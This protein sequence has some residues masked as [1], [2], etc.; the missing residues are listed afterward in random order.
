NEF[1]SEIA[2]SEP[3]LGMSSA[4]SVGVMRQ[5]LAELDKEPI[6]EWADLDDGDFVAVCNY[7][8]GAV[9][10]GGGPT[11]TCPDGEVV[12]IAVP[13]QAQYLVTADG[14]AV[15]DVTQDNLEPPLERPGCP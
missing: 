9:D 13:N 11:T 4:S 12:S 14:V 5:V 15:R 6:A 7:P 1:M 2:D 3:R 10:V 8:L